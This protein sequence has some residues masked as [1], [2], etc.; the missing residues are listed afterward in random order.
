MP[1]ELNGRVIVYTNQVPYEADVLRSNLYQ[2]TAVSRLSQTILGTGISNSTLA[3]D[4]PCTP[5][6][7][8]GLQ[9][10]IGAGSLYSFVNL[11]NTAYGVLPVDTDPNHK[12]LKQAI[13]FDPTTLNTPAP[14]LSGNSIIYLIQAIL[15]TVDIN[16]VSRPYFNSADPSMPIFENNY[17]TRQDIV[18][19][20]VK[21]SAQAPSPTPPVPDAGYVPL[22]Y[23]TVA[24]G[25]TSIISGNI[26]LAANAPFITESLTQKV[27]SATV[28][29]DFVSKTQEQNSSNVYANDIG[30]INA[31]VAN[32]SPA[33]GPYQD[34]MHVLIK[35]ANSNTGPATLNVSGRGADNIQQIEAGSLVNLEGGEIQGGGIYDLIRNS[36]IW[37]LMN[38]TQSDGGVPVGTI[39]DSAGGTVD[40]GF[41]PWIG[42]LY[43]RADYAALFNKIGTAWG[44]GDGSTTFQVGP[45]NPRRVCV[46]AGGSGSGILGNTVG[47]L[48]GEETHSLTSAENGQHTHSISLSS[49]SSPNIPSTFWMEVPGYSGNKMDPGAGHGDY[50]CHLSINNSG[51]GN[52]HNIMQPSMVVLKQVK[53]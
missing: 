29:G 32:P 21:A 2:M 5:I 34:G 16:D 35:A 51:S 49:E 39:L 46:G 44:A 1:L 43:N 8:P 27:S 20:V 25:Q 38:P 17:D 45:S 36:G 48:G 28:S 22:Y 9:V 12:L 7:P 42:N 19:L 18:S 4:L 50:L 53:Y 37:Q 3:A 6:S 14:T 31:L 40:P 13:N 11:D 41:L 23:V 24:N 52:P 30:T 10:V 47:S 26:T 15:Q 33:Y